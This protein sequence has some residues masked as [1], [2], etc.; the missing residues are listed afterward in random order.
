MGVVTSDIVRM[1]AAGLKTDFDEAYLQY[2]EDAEWMLI[3]E[4]IPTT[5][6]S[7]DYGHLGAGPVMKKFTD[8]A[9][10]QDLNAYQYNL[11][12]SLYKA[13]IP[14]QRRALEDDQYG[15]IQRR[16]NNLA[17]EAVRHWNEL[18]FTGL[19]AGFA[20]IC[21]DGQYFFD[22]DHAESGS[23]QSNLLSSP[24]ADGSLE[25]ARRMMREFV[26]DKGKPF[27]AKPNGL[28]VGPKNERRATDLLGSDVV[29]IRVGD[30]TAGTGATAATPISNY[31]KGKYF[32]VVNEYITNWN[33]F[34]LDTSR[35]M[36][37]LFIQ[38]RSDVP[39][40][41]ETDMEDGG[42]KLKEEYTFEVRGRY[43]QGYGPWWMAVGSNATS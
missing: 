23:N 42:A 40:T 43:E 25:T 1:T 38:S 16:V 28:V 4:E 11:R 37:P 27:G 10:K 12:D 13:S 34:V 39:I 41:V 5:L 35:P 36:K 29:V 21:Y 18:V 14:V 7:Q 2:R 32:L 33:W 8:E 24:L 15:L 3:A 9:E 26:N 19:V 22:V 17:F 20:A 30:G 6:P 31:H